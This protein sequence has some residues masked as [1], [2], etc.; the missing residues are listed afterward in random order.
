M[1]ASLTN[2]QQYP[3]A[4]KGNDKTELVYSADCLMKFRQTCL[5]H[6]VSWTQTRLE[7]ENASVET[8]L[9]LKHKILQINHPDTCLDRKKQIT[10]VSSQDGAW[11]RRGAYRSS[12]E[13]R[14]SHRARF[15]KI[16]VSG[17]FTVL[18]FRTSVS[19]E[20]I[21]S[22]DISSPQHLTPHVH[23]A[24]SVKATSESST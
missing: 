14:S 24:L 12:T 15:D 5:K 23:S 17:T 13:Y 4:S 20:K 1:H 2:V 6:K 21:L 22:G 9:I 16:N 8:K 19:A 18:T 7:P 3:A 10:K 11:W